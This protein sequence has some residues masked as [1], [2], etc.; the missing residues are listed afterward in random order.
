MSLAFGSSLYSNFTSILDN[1]FNQLKL[2]DDLLEQEYNTLIDNQQVIISVGMKRIKKHEKNQE[3]FRHEVIAKIEPSNKK[4]YKF[5]FDYFKD[6]TIPDPDKEGHLKQI[7]ALVAIE[8][9][10][11]S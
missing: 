11:E 10:V 1:Q 4:V 3:L 2:D 6:Q 7:Y 9:I 8:C 5:L